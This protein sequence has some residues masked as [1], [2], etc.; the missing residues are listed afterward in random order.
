M[1]VRLERTRT[2]GLLAGLLDYPAAGTAADAD[3]CQALLDVSA[4]LAAAQLRGFC[5]FARQTPLGRLQEIYSAFFDLN[6]VC[7]PYVGY[8]LFGEDYKRSVFLLGLKARYRVGG[9]EAGDSDMPD[10]LSTV[11]RY[12]AGRRG[13]EE[14]DTLVREG[15]LPALER[16]IAK[17]ESGGHPFEGENEAFGSHTGIPRR[18]DLERP[19]QLTGHSRGEVLGAGFLFETTGAAGE[20]GHARGRRQH[21]YLLLLMALYV[22]LREVWFDA[23]EE[24]A[25]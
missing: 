1:D 21:P 7:H 16:M 8:Q 13:D 6:P 24:N 10:R 18:M 22:L 4:P 12:V 14:A 9:F 17:P 3:A 19:H 2:L 20:P 25:A 23:R 5:D 11:L 15:L